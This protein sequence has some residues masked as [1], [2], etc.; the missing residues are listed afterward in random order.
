[1]KRNSI[2]IVLLSLV[3]VGCAG[4]AV[5]TSKSYS[6]AVINRGAI[7]EAESIRVHEYLNYYDQQL[8]S[9]QSEAM[10]MEVRL[11]RTVLPADGGE[12]W[13]QV[14][15]QAR[16]SGIAERTP[17]NLA[18]VLD[19]SGSMNA[20]D[21]MPFLKSS[22][23]LF[24]QSL[25]PQDRVAI[26]TYSDQAQLIHPSSL[27]GDGRW[28]ESTVNRLRPGGAT[29]LHAGLMMGFS[30]V[31]NHF[32]RRR[33]NRV[34]LL[35]DGIANRGVVEP[36]I[37][38]S[39]AKSFN[40]RGI[41]LSTIGLGLDLNDDLL[42]ELAHQG[43]G[44][45]HFIDSA[46]EM[47]RVFR[48]EVSGLVERVARDV[49]VS[50]ETVPGVELVEIAGAEWQPA[51]EGARIQLQDMG[52]G[53]SQVL[54][55][56]LTLGRSFTGTRPLVDVTTSY[57]D[58]FA[59]RERTLHQTLAVHV[60]SGR[61]D[62]PFQDLQVRRNVV[63]YRSAQAL[64]DIDHLFEAGQYERAYLLAEKMEGELRYLANQLEDSQLAEDADLFARYQVTL[65]S[66]LGYQPGSDFTEGD[67]PFSPTPL[68]F[69]EQLPTVE[70]R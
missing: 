10:A 5:D 9:P 22:L 42:S 14:G 35:T 12:V 26:V 54:L 47:D 15:L 70:V 53:D 33:D 39:Q 36:D 52:A 2:W 55:A 58:A 20:P 30:E 18:L 6:R 40:D 19:T 16:E 17:L 4:G 24:L 34:L 56:K 7:V 1:M 66:A 49:V 21:K 38:A 41:Q 59:E 60:E 32:D 3:L 65:A 25:R 45:Y 46:Q 13:L 51:S 11:G 31:D 57:I 62:E 8:P 69:D 29:N 61:Y 67:S 68:P 44:V 64:I 28:I 23:R 63:L 50:L 27:V 37:I 43:Q 48:E